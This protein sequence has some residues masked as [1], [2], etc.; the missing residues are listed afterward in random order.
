MILTVYQ[1]TQLDAHYQSCMESN[2]T[3]ELPMFVYL[4]NREESAVE[5]QIVLTVLLS[6]ACCP[7]T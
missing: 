5:V 7:A 2:V 1:K 4:R 3:L 6:L